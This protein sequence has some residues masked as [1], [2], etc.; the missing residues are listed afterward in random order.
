MM[1]QPASFFFDVQP[2]GLRAAIERAIRN[3]TQDFAETRWSDALASRGETRGWGGDVFGSRLID[4]RVARLHCSPEMAFKTI[5]QLGG[6]KG[7]YYADWLWRLRGLLDLAVGGAG[8]RR[9][10][11]NQYKIR[12][13]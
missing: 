6:D 3:E 11:R 1:A 7:W 2:M 9:G 5:E 13:G 4:S 10:R 12:V 8:M